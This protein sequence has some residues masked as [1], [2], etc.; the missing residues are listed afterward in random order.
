[1]NVEV[2]NGPRCSHY[3]LFIST[4]YALTEACDGARVGEYLLAVDYETTN[5]SRILLASCY[6][7]SAY[8]PV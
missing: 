3:K 2:G 1:M 6:F 4:Y 7:H 5:L 8:D